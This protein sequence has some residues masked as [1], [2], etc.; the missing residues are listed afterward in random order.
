MVG[1][2]DSAT[3]VSS[4]VVDM[5][6]HDDRAASSPDTIIRAL[7]EET[8]AVRGLCNFNGLLKA[9]VVYPERR[10]TATAE[11]FIVRVVCIYKSGEIKVEDLYC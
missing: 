5:K 11:N 6:R 9:D 7:L 2:A 4:S 8:N 1:I 3:S 10:R